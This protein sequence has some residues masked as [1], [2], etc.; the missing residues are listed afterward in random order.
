[1]HFHA[2]HT[3]FFKSH[4]SLWRAALALGLTLCVVVVNVGAQSTTVSL[5][6]SG[7]GAFLLVV[8][9]MGGHGRANDEFGWAR[10]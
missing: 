1:M 8:A 7:I 4:R 6:G 5:V 9:H 2:D 3:L 10:A